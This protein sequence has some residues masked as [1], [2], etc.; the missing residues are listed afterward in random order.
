MEDLLYGKDITQHEERKNKVIDKFHTL[1][2]E[3]HQELNQEEQSIWQK[4]ILNTFPS[5]AITTDTMKKAEEKD[6]YVD[7]MHIFDLVTL[8]LEIE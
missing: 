6:L 5:P 4:K 8:L 1:Y 7:E 3:N 2:K